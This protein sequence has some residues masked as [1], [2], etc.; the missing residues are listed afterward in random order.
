MNTY[1][2]EIWDGYIMAWDELYLGGI[3]GAIYTRDKVSYFIRVN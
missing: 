3:G 2:I 1:K